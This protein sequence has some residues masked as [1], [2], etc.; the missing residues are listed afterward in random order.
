VGEEAAAV[1]ERLREEPAGADELAR[2]TGVPAGGLAVL[3]TELE[4]AGAIVEED[5]VYRA[6]R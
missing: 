1:L 4:L 2:T 3:L 6:A 5:G